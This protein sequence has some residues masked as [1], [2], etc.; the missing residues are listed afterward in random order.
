MV[1]SV[2]SFKVKL[3][4]CVPSRVTLKNFRR[5]DGV[6]YVLSNAYFHVLNKLIGIKAQVLF[7]ALHELNPCI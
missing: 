1:F 2:Y 4:L 5:G 3:L 7:T 6:F